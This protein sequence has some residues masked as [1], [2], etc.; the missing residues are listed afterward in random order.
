MLHFDVPMVRGNT[1]LHN[2]LAEVI[3]AQRSGLLFT[4]KG[5]CHLVHFD[6][7]VDAVSR[8]VTRLQEVESEPVLKIEAIS[9]ADREGSIRAAGGKF[10]LMGQ[11]GTTALLLSIS[12]GF[13]LPYASPSSGVRCDR[14]NKP[15]NKRDR[16]WYHY[17]PPHKRDPSN[18]HICRF[19]PG[20]LP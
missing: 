7:M 12:E 15:P 1:S 6:R 18:W 5:E 10:G 13:G 3:D 4:T 8:G 19:C 16:E 20:R 2:A 14:P 11:V 9:D 17:Y